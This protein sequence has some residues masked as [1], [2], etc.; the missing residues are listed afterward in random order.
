M[1]SHPA[2][3]RVL[4]VLA[5]GGCVESSAQIATSGLRPAFEAV[6]DEDGFTTVSASLETTTTL[7]KNVQLSGGD[8]LEVEHEGER[9]GLTE[10]DSGS[11]Y[12]ATLGQVADGALL[13]M[14]FLRG[15]RDD[16]APS[17]VVEVPEGFVVTSPSPG[18]TF[19]RADDDIEIAWSE[20]LAGGNMDYTVSGDC[21]VYRS[22]SEPDAGTLTIRAG[23]LGSAG[24]GDDEE[25]TETTNKKTKG[26]AEEAEATEPEEEE[27]CEITVRLERRIEGTVDPGFGDDCCFEAVQARE[28]VLV[29]A[30]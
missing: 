25:P 11:A 6:T 30:P 17:S 29:S 14:A 22:W 7:V 1:S 13:T 28:L 3:G 5:M 26:E 21:I 27:T 10:L 18:E 15:E 2:L 19:S 8:V 9:R 16:D 24:G 20:S 4:M 23:R 12:Q